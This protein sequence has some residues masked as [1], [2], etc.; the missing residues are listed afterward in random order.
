M[1]IVKNHGAG[2][3][4]YMNLTLMRYA[5]SG[6]NYTDDRSDPAGNAAVAVRQL[7]RNLVALANVAPKVR[8]LQGFYAPDSGPEVYN[9]E[10]ARF[11]DGQNVYLACVVN[12]QLRKPELEHYGQY[13]PDP[14]WAVGRLGRVGHAAF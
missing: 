3:S 9:F 6:G 14:V 10:K 4:V 12:S 2:K 5:R 11:V 7:V 13:G 1:L 8:V